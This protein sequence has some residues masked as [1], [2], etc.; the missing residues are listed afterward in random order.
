[1]CK[2]SSRQKHFLARC[3]RLSHNI[4]EFNTISTV[5]LARQQYL[6]PHDPF[7]TRGILSEVY[8]LCKNR[9]NCHSMCQPLLIMLFQNCLFHSVSL[10][11]Q[12]TLTFLNLNI[13]Y[14]PFEY[15]YAETGKLDKAPAVYPCLRLL[16]CK[17][18]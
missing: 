2:N 12:Y 15:L 17:S 8:H 11:D 13:K 1:M 6:L 4:S 9:G 14:M 18:W 16:M 3:M 7:I 5:I 10:V